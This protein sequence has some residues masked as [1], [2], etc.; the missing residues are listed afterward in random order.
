[1]ASAKNN[2]KR[3]TDSL[4]ILGIDPGLQVTGYGIVDATPRRV[5]LVEGGIIRCSTRYALE[6]RLKMIF[7]GMSEV[8]TEYQ[9]AMVVVEELYSTYRHPRTAILMA[10]A[11]GVI[12]LA[13]TQANLSI[14]SYSAT[15]V[16]RALTGSGHASKAQ[17]QRVVQQRLRLAKTPQP[18]DVAD[19]LALALCHSQRCF[20]G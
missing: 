8:L 10:H 19:A 1:M 18:P 3:P 9:P 4:R 12:Y 11:R 16:K 7:E 2:V 14:T 17:M 5:T 6:R 15:E 20:R 13:A